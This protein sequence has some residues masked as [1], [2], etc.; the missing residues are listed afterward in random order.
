MSDEL[1]LNEALASVLNGCNN[2]D[3]NYGAIKGLISLL[4]A[5][6]S[7]VAEFYSTYI[8]PPAT[9]RLYLFLEKLVE[10]LNYLKEKFENFDEA[11]LQKDNFSTNLLRVR[12]IVIRTHQEQKL[13][14]LKN[15]VL[16]SVLP[17]SPNEDMQVLFLD[18]IDS[19]TLT[20]LSILEFLNDAQ[21]WCLK[22]RP[23]TTYEECLMAWKQNRPIHTDSLL[24][25]FFPNLFENQEFYNQVFMD[26]RS[27]GLIHEKDQN[28]SSFGINSIRKRHRIDRAVKEENLQ[29]AFKLATENELKPLELN[30]LLLN[31]ALQHKNLV[32]KFG[33]QF[34]DFMKSP[35]N[36]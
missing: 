6:G 31:A 11:W 25:I 26:L 13:V 34:L 8:T 18:F 22:F 4:P 10:E 7:P 32:S 20:H 24:K 33:Q 29:H 5:V 36:I 2:A 17:E 3:K 1:S 35:L 30:K 16:N 15:S 23:E 28:L 12:E 21:I 14:A 27:K 19:F 9:K